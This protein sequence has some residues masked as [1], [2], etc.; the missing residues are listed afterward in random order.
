MKKKQAA[1][2]SAFLS[3][4]MVLTMLPT[5]VFARSPL[6]QA[7][8]DGEITAAVVAKEEFI[9]ANADNW[10]ISYAE[11]ERQLEPYEEQT[12]TP[13]DDSYQEDRVIIQKSK[14][15]PQGGQLVCRATV[16]V[17]KDPATGQYVE[18][19]EVT[20]SSL[21]V[22][23]TGQRFEFQKGD[24]SN[25][26]IEGNIIQDSEWIGT[27]SSVYPWLA[28]PTRLNVDYNGCVTCSVKSNFSIHFIGIVSVDTSGG[29]ELYRN[30]C[31][32]QFVFSVDR[33]SDYM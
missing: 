29:F 26:S 30:D 6:E 5:T 20:S 3:L 4:V 8:P 15:L 25:L 2:L 10:G 16:Y 33:L 24:S 28:S 1:C 14:D 18:F 31:D 12:I 22:E 17:R 32:G 13:S 9:Q 11:A 27:S 21:S 7:P 19:S 23:A